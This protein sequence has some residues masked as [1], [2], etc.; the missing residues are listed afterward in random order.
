RTTSNMQFTTTHRNAF[1][2]SYEGFQYTIKQECKNS[3]EWRC[4][5]KSCTTSL[6]LY[7]RDNKPI[8]RE[9]DVHTCT[10]TSPKEKLLL[11]K[12]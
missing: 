1:V 8:T 6:S 9:L 3:I 5:V 2:L 11:M 4:R 7:C 12:L 10:P